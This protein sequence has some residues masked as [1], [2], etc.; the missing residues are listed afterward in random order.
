MDRAE[1]AVV[2]REMQWTLDDLAF[3]LGKRHD[4]PTVVELAQVESALRSL[5]ASVRAAIDA[6][7]PVLII[8]S[9]ATETGP[10][11]AGLND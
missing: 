9:N 5:A 1:L 2:M 7:Q 6:D 8:D 3:R 4:A 11:V 10:A